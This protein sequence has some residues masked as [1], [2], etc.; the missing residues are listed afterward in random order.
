MFSMV[1][2]EIQ[3]R[4]VQLC[5]PKTTQDV[6]CLEVFYTMSA[7]VVFLVCMPILVY[8]TQNV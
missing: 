2:S 5:R 6:K 1:E 3:E 7:S 8:L 4:S